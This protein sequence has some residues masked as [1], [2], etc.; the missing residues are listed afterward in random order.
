M[1][2][3]YKI[4]I[5]IIATI[6]IITVAVLYII[7]NKNVTK[8]SNVKIL[9]CYENEIENYAE[10]KMPFTIEKQ[11]EN[12]KIIVNGKEYKDGERFYKTGKYKVE[13]CENF[14]KEETY[15][16]IK[17]I[18]KNEKTEYNIY[19]NTS[20][21][22]TFMAMLN[23]AQNDDVNGFFWTRKNTSID[24]DG[25]KER[26]HNLKLSEYLGNN[27]E[28]DFKLKIV[29]E[30]K[31]YIKDV[32]Q[33]DS[34]AFFNLYVDDYRFYLDLELF[35]KIGIGDNRYNYYYY[36][37]GTSS[38]VKYYTSKGGS[39]HREFKMREENG[40]EDFL[41]EKEE[42]NQIVEKIRTNQLEYNEIP[43]SYFA[44]ESGI[45]YVYDYMLIALLRDNV[46]YLL[47][48]PQKIDFKDEKVAKEMENAN[49][50]KMDLKKQFS[51]LSEEQQKTFLSNIFL[52]KAEFDSKYFE[53][54]D[55][56]YL[57]IT[58]TNPFYGDLNK[59]KFEE[60]IKKVK[61]DY[62][63]EYTILYKP[64]PSAL[65][66]E[67][68]QEFLENLNI[69][70]L[71]GKMP[72]EAIMFVYPNIKIGGYASSLYMS[73]EEGQTL[74]FFAEKPEDLVEPLNT[75]YSEMF[76]NAKLYN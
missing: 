14:K 46:N 7:T 56:K 3:K 27:S 43:G 29:P 69:K 20:T 31:E 11:N 66:N 62:G 54:Q 10:N 26:N 9:D 49:F 57:I 55:G 21:L 38:Y 36:S 70:I 24:I 15:I 59:E 13:V 28:T 37:D 74:F 39:I 40:Y 44:D 75:L 33:S 71:P 30:I 23:I 4:I 41:K 61:E 47:Q 42:Y 76:S 67:E 6:I 32:L 51:E 2:N 25:I 48:Y 17:D 16:E 50:V 65:P 22:P 53:N 19:I 12:Q 1:K 8:F 60:L 58:G 18:E 72:M 5:G 45:G 73:A 64:H 35:G 34:N 63:E 68:Q 52:D